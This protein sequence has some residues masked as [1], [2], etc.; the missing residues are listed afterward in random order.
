MNIFS[1]RFKKQSDHP[2]NWSISSSELG[3][4]S[5]DNMSRSAS[6]SSVAESVKTLSKRSS[7]NYLPRSLSE[8]DNSNIGITKR[9]LEPAKD[10]LSTGSKRVIGGVAY[11]ISVAALFPVL[12]I[13]ALQNIIDV[14]RGIL[15]ETLPYLAAKQLY[16][17]GRDESDHPYTPDVINKKAKEVEEIG[18]KVSTVLIELPITILGGIAK[19]PFTT[20]GFLSASVARWGLDK[21]PQKN[22]DVGYLNPIV[23]QEFHAEAQE[24]LNYLISKIEHK[25]PKPLTAPMTEESQTK[26]VYGQYTGE[27]KLSKAVSDEFRD[28]LKTLSTI[29]KD[30]AKLGEKVKKPV[31]SPPDDHKSK[32]DRRIQGNSN[33]DLL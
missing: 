13:V 6:F 5:V 12:G 27:Q 14:G 20:L 16:K 17:L 29:K 3:D 1:D 11:G 25:I 15:F 33:I 30:I 8:L 10:F 9:F 23:L 26:G 32:G 7:D 18:K 19:A 21:N 31:E 28:F 4:A 24:E 22:E 2:D